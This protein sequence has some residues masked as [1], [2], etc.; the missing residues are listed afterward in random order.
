MGS[1][2]GKDDASAEGDDLGPFYAST[3]GE[4][5]SVC[6]TGAS[7]RAEV[8]AGD[9]GE[10]GGAGSERTTFRSA[11]GGGGGPDAGKISGITE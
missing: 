8:W 2:P 3:M 10:D 11:N 7:G 6:G 1:A 5:H 9:D 4:D